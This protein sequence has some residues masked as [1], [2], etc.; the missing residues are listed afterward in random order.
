MHS[1][2]I[3]L[4]ITVDED[5]VFT[6]M[7]GH[8]DYV[9]EIEKDN[10][11]ALEILEHIGT[12]DKDALTFRADKAKVQEQLEIAYGIY[13]AAAINSFD[14]FTNQGKVWRAADALEDEFGVRIITDWSGCTDPWLE[15]LR[16]LWHH[17]ELMDK[18]WDI[19]HV[20]DYHF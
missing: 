2:I 4:N 5:E 14:D 11:W 3:A 10:E 20:F 16:D 13:R 8:A 19:T 1:R 6:Q 15:F 9:D 18:T 12:V 17:P 7:S